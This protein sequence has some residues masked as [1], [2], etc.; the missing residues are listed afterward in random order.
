[1]KEMTPAPKK[2]TTT[3]TKQEMLDA[4]NALLVKMNETNE[5]KMKPEEKIA[6]K[7]IV[8]AIE[9]ADAIDMNG[10]VKNISDLKL[11]L[12]TSLTELA[13]LLE[14][15]FI[16][17]QQIKKSV[18]VK[19]IEL[20]EHFE[21]RKEA[22]SLLALIE[23]QNEQKFEFE[24]EMEE[25]KVNLDN[26][27]SEK[28]E[29]YENDFYEKKEKYEND[30][31]EKKLKFE[32]DI[33]DKKVKLENEILEK[34]LEWEKEKKNHAEEIKFRDESE[35]LQRKR[36]KEEFY[37]NF[38]KDKKQT[39]DSL[40]NE[41]Q[42]LTK[43]LQEMKEDTEKSLNEREKAINE[44]EEE[45]KMLREK[46]KGWDRELQIAV[47]KAVKDAT[48]RLEMESAHKEQLLRKEIEGERNVMEIKISSLDKVIKDQAEQIS[49][50]NL[51]IDKSYSQVQD[52]AMKAVE[53]TSAPKQHYQQGNQEI[54]N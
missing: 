2:L 13:D 44:R 42:L 33:N 3:N 38:E 47:S 36:E 20:E 22:A 26:E 10:I 6:K 30:F 32:T 14:S 29:K 41:K 28:K 46:V 53:S 7:E 40:E 43:H 25:K 45:L 18:H 48:E 50:L 15:E 39:L 23:A 1:M 4:Y 24:N 16:K 34:R 31:Y 35:T 5:A 37:Y 27:L 54:K 52:I 19:E 9:T 21:I 51:Q 49:K 8:E 12:G 11:K 17:Y